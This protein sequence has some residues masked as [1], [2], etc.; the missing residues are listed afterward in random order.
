MNWPGT[1]PRIGIG[2]TLD[3]D[4]W[5]WILM[6]PIMYLLRDS[7]ELQAGN[8]QELLDMKFAFIHGTPPREVK[9]MDAFWKG[10]YA[11]STFDG[12]VIDHA[13]TPEDGESMFRLK[14]P[15]VGTVSV[16]ET[17][18][19]SFATTR[20]PVKVNGDTQWSWEIMRECA[21]NA[22]YPQGGTWI[23]D[24]AGWC[25]G[26]VVDTKDFELT[27][28][29]AGQDEFSVDYDITYDPD[30]NYRF[31][32][33]IVA[34]GDPN[35]EYDVEISQILSPSDDKLI[36]VEPHQ[37]QHRRIRNNGSQLLTSCQFS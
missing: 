19:L 28:L 6:Y 27:P 24:R 36:P 8:W 10:Q 17:I 4:G 5:T 7:V 30:G 32:G 20:T 9:R 34:Y 12:N 14:T 15:R 31:E 37:N 11:L 22:L 2:L 35:M 1:L 25:P 3:D 29:V 21:D 16:L 18:V 33:Q 23:Y 13:F 26:A